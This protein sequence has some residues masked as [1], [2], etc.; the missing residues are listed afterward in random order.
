L[1]FEG[2]ASDVG[3]IVLSLEIPDDLRNQFGLLA[4]KTVKREQSELVGDPY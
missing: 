2:N 4:I 1:E 3:V